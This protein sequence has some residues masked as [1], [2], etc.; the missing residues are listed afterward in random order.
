MSVRWQAKQQLQAQHRKTPRRFRAIRMH[1]ARN[2]G[3]RPWRC[4]KN[5][6]FARFSSLLL[7]GHDS[8]CHL[9]FRAWPHSCAHGHPALAPMSGH[10]ADWFHRGLGKTWPRIHAAGTRVFTSAN[11]SIWASDCLRAE[12]VDTQFLA[13]LSCTS[14]HRCCWSRHSRW[15]RRSGVRRTFISCRCLRCMGHHLPGMIRAYG[16]RAL[17]ERFK[18]RFI[19]APLFLLAVCV[20]FSGGTWR[21]FC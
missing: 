4:K 11:G 3:T 18:W 6:A 17:F 19:L 12:A 14:A 9:V 16:D 5:R 8:P 13:G 2:I 1:A 15:P 7:S 21:E 10:K 20:A